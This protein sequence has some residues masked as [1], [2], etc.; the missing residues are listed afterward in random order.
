M[1]SDKY[2][3]LGVDVEQVGAKLLAGVNF[4]QLPC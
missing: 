2:L 3:V 1:Q 4:E